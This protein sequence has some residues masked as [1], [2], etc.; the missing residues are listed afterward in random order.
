ML[1]CRFQKCSDFGELKKVFRDQ[2]VH[3][4]NRPVYS[5]LPRFLLFSYPGFSFLLL[6]RL[7]FAPIWRFSPLVWF[8]D[9]LELPVRDRRDQ[10][11]SSPSEKGQEQCCF[12]FNE[13]EKVEVLT[14]LVSCCCFN[15]APYKAPV[16]AKPAA[17]EAMMSGRAFSGLDVIELAMLEQYWRS[18]GKKRAF[19]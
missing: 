7:L 15:P 5:P 18:S 12:A 16:T 6:S 1:V 3:F 11:S 8:L 14:F 19:E 9:E 4:S 2:L 10:Q 13:G 17:R